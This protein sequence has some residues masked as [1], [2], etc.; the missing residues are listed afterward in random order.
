MASLA[1]YHIA[2][3][4][5]RRQCDGSCDTARIDSHIGILDD[6]SP[7]K[8]IYTYLV[9]CQLFVDFSD[10]IVRQDHSSVCVQGSYGPCESSRLQ[11]EW[12]D[13]Q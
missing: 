13:E 3:G 8:A 7:V 9:T 10:Q 2:I 5:R 1:N 12:I 4:F 6:V 11:I